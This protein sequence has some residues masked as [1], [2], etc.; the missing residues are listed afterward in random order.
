MVAVFGAPFLHSACVQRDRGYV[1]L[2]GWLASLR[3]RQGQLDSVRGDHAAKH[4]SHDFGLGVSR[5]QLGAPLRKRRA[6]RRG[7]RCSFAAPSV[8]YH[9]ASWSDSNLR[10]SVGF[11]RVSAGRQP[12]RRVEDVLEGQEGLVPRGLRED[13]QQRR[14]ALRRS[15]MGR[16]RGR[17]TLPAFVLEAEAFR[18]MGA[19]RV[20]G[21]AA[22]RADHVHG[23]A[24]SSERTHHDGSERIGEGLGAGGSGKREGR[25]RS[26]VDGPSLHLVVHVSEQALR[27]I[28]SI[29]RVL[30]G[31]QRPR[32]GSRSDGESVRFGVERRL[33][34]AALSAF[35]Q[36]CRCKSVHITC[37]SKRWRSSRTPRCFS[38]SQTAISSSGTRYRGKSC[39]WSLPTSPARP[40]TPICSS[41]SRSLRSQCAALP[42]HPPLPWTSSLQSPQ[43]PLN[44]SKACRTTRRSRP[45]RRNPAR[46]RRDPR[47]RRPLR[48]RNR[49]RSGRT[50]RL[51]RSR[52]ISPPRGSA[53]RCWCSIRRARCRWC[54]SS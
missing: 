27:G 33:G 50:L 37:R 52:R 16:R 11:R 49:A 15:A 21:V 1:R 3:G 38:A 46:N 30:A 54:R 25:E 22:P 44:P 31:R 47:A 2:C 45:N 39:G 18:R 40:P 43:S 13:Q 20:R 9:I 42:L 53:T 35:A 41:R 19:L 34:R 10:S 32:G 28:D 12:N 36:H 29:G 8:Q 23:G 24:S 17:R 51:P 5:K 26:R 6:V 14:V 4:P 48:P 7:V